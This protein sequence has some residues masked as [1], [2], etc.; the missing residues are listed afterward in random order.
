MKEKLK[1]ITRNEFL[2]DTITSSFQILLFIFLLTLLIHEF[3]P[4]YVEHYISLN[5][6][7]VIVIV[8]G[9]LAVLFE[10]EKPLEKEQ[11][12]ELIKKDYVFIAI[13]GIAGAVIVWYKIKDIGWVS[14][15][16][17]AMSGIL[18]ITLSILMFEESGEDDTVDDCES[19]QFSHKIKSV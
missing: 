8:M 2:Q 1:E 16:I 5:N 19:S 13:T 3:K 9:V 7:L 15:L 18:I 12:G 10:P 14:Y 17:G 4:L 11:P 6:F